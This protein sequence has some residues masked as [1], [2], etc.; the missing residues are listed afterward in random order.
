[1][2]DYRKMYESD[3]LGAWDFEKDVTLTI[4]NVVGGEIGGQQGRKK[5]KKPLVYFEGTPKALVLNKVNGK[6]IAAMYGKKTE[7]WA[8]KKITLFATQ[9]DVAGEQVD[10]IRIRPGVPK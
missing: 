4:K 1:M 9:T 3:Y 8:G 2:P 5:E 7:D 6:S 10:C